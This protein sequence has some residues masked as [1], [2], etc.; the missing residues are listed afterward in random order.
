MISERAVRAILLAVGLYHVLQGGL[1]LLDPGTFFDEIGRYGVENTHYVGDN[2]SFALA[3]GIALLLAAGRSSW[4]E[5]VLVLVAIWY[6][7]HALNHLF[8]IDE[9]RSDA[10]GVFDTAALALGALLAAWLA[11][12]SARLDV[13]GPPARR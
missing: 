13:R 1:A 6:G 12:A 11:R 9:A 10:R 2:G 3:V 5:P 4:R 8:D 7:L